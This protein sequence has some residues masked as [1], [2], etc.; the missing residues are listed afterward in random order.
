MRLSG[1]NDSLRF[2]ALSVGYCL[3]VNNFS[4]RTCNCH[5]LMATSRI[6]YRAMSICRDTSTDRGSHPQSIRGS[7]RSILTLSRDSAPRTSFHNAGTHCH[8]RGPGTQL[9]LPPPPSPPP[10]SLRSSC[11]WCGATAVGRRRRRGSRCRGGPLGA[12]SGPAPPCCPRP[13][14]A[15]HPQSSRVKWIRVCEEEYIPCPSPEG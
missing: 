5:A 12:W 6:P 4:T 3:S 9:C 15:I 10:F 11:L 8:V 1:A 13:G 7:G 2:T 14:P